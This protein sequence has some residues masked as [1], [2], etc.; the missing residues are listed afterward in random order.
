MR[1][2]LF[3]ALLAAT[4]SS[5]AYAAADKEQQDGQTRSDCRVEGEAVG[6]QGKDLED[7][8]ENCVTDLQ[9]VTI[10]NQAWKKR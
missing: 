1:R 2:N 8:V 3:N 7:F 5:P 9:D 6:L 10:E 4:L